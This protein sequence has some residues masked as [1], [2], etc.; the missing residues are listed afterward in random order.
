[1]PRARKSTSTG[2]LNR[3]ATTAAK[4]LSTRTQPIRKSRSSSAVAANVTLLDLRRR[5]SSLRPGAVDRIEAYA[6]ALAQH[7]PRRDLVLLGRRPRA[8]HLDRTAGGR[9]LERTGLRDR[10]RLGLCHLRL[11][12]CLRRRGA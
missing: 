11:R 1:M 2:T 5:C 9:R 8:L 4:T 12:P 7:R 3:R 6:P 10:L